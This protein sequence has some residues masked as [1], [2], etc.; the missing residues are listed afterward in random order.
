MPS[1]DRQRDADDRSRGAGDQRPRRRHAGLRHR[2]VPQALPAQRARRHRPDAREERRHRGLRRQAHRRTAM[3]LTR[4]SAAILAG[5]AG[6][7]ALGAIAASAAQ[8]PPPPSKLVAP[9]TAPAVKPDAAPEATDS[10]TWIF[11]GILRGQQARRFPARSITGK[12]D[13]QFELKLADGAT[14]DG[15]DLKPS[16]GMVQASTRSQC[17]DGRAMRALF[18]PQPR[19]TLEGLRACRRRAL[20]DD[21]ASPRHAAVARAEADHR[22]AGADTRA[23]DGSAGPARRARSRLTERARL[24]RDGG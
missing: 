24:G 4:G 1:A 17:T 3:A 9:A 14:C 8:T 6:V 23:P 21:R 10:D 22:P 18:V 12:S 16:L 2:P 13:T 20:R 15:A 5:L 19:Q 7:L 11:S